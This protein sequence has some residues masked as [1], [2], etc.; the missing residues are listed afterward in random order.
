MR[1]L[2]LTTLLALLPVL[3]VP[4]GLNVC[5]CSS[6]CECSEMAAAEESSLPPCCVKKAA[7]KCCSGPSGVKVSSTQHSCRRLVVPEQTQS[8][9]RVAP[10]EGVS[11]PP[12]QVIASIPAAADSAARMKGAATVSMLPHGGAP[13]PR[14]PLL[15]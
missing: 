8:A 9:S 14:P 4:F 6:E 12:L 7:K 2:A 15:I 10:V 1:I 5:V 13:P 11:H 3:V